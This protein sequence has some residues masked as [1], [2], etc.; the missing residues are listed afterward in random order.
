MCGPGT[1]AGD[2]LMEPLMSLLSGW[3]NGP[4]TD[5]RWTNRP[6]AAEKKPSSKRRQ[7]RLE[8]LEGRMLLTINVNTFQD[9]SNVVLDFFTG[10]KL[11][12]LRAAINMANQ[13]KSPETI[14]VPAG[15]YQL[16]QGKV[17]EITSP[18]KVT[19]Q[20]DAQNNTVV[21][22]LNKCGVFQVDKGSEVDFE[23]LW[24]Q[25][26]NTTGGNVSKGGGIEND[27]KVEINNCDFYQNTAYIGGGLLNN[28]TATVTNS[29]FSGNLAKGAGGGGVYNNSVLSTTNCVF[30]G[31]KAVRL[32]VPGSTAYGGGLFNDS[33]QATITGGT[34]AQNTADDWGGG[35]WGK[36]TTHISNVR[37]ASNKAS[38]GGGVANGGSMT[39]SGATFTNNSA[40][41]QGGGIYNDYYAK[42]LTVDTSTISNNHAG[43]A[44]GGLYDCSW[45]SKATIDKQTHQNSSGNTPTDFDP[46]P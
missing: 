30:W 29:V 21:D 4:A 28:G 43:V 44:G 10:T 3:N 5:R 2:Q 26:G 36:A 46:N 32:A 38:T 19:I 25:G 13:E 35:L 7:P 20:G 37:F 24:I 27:G 14:V 6:R 41:Y 9:Y 45:Y 8:S 31:N 15:N 40:T 11:V 16:T 42:L 18:A 34:F 12:S 23:G 39:V 33:G 1:F 17:L 22:A